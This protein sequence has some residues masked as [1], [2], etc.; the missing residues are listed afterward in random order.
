MNLKDRLQIE[1]S[2]QDNELLREVLEYVEITSA[3]SEALGR[4]HEVLDYHDLPVEYAALNKALERSRAD[5]MALADRYDKLSDIADNYADISHKLIY[6][7]A[8]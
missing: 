4:L 5:Y 3:D 7:S 1:L 2:R 6:G 8:E